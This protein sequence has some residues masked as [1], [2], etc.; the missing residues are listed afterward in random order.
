MTCHRVAPAMSRGQIVQRLEKQLW[1]KQEFA[2]FQNSFG[3]R[4]LLYTH[5][6]NDTESIIIVVGLG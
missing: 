5:T 2:D 1:A 6:L 4:L 3:M